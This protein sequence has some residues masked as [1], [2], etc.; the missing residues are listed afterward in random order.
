MINLQQIYHLFMI[1]TNF[2]KIHDLRSLFYYSLSNK[3][4]LVKGYYIE[5]H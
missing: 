5:V 1:N 4:V 3:L 2:T